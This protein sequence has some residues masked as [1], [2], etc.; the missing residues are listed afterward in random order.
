MTAALAKPMIPSGFPTTSP[1]RMPQAMRLVSRSRHAPPEKVTPALASANSGNTRNETQSF[2]SRV[3]RSDADSVLLS[4]A[5]KLPS[6]FLAFLHVAASHRVA[7]TPRHI[8][9]NILK[10]FQRQRSPSSAP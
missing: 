3:R 4:S 2:N 1:S 10:I 7:K 8:G 5:S 9:R 6:R